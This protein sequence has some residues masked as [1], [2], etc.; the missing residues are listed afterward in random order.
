M[1]LR[2]IMT[3]EVEI[4]LLSRRPRMLLMQVP[5]RCM[6]EVFVKMWPDFLV[7]QNCFVNLYFLSPSSVRILHQ[8]S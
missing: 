1:I 6:C 5:S 4:C 8:I 2:F 3:L 7:V